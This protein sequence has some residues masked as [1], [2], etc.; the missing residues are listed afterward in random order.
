M[1]RH[2]AELEFRGSSPVYERLALALA[3]PPEL[4]ELMRAHGAE[5]ARL[6]ATRTT[7]TNEAGRAALLRPAFG[8]AA[9][10][11][12]GRAVALVE[13]GTSAGLLLIPDRYGY[14]YARDGRQETF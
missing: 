7:Q 14:R 9:A 6:C 10:L 11:A 2:F 12:T 3:D 1:F 4:A 8:R 5:L 13:L